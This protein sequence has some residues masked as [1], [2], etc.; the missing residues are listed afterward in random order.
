[1]NRNIILIAVAA[2]VLIILLISQIDFPQAAAA[3]PM[4]DQKQKLTLAIFGEEYYNIHTAT[5]THWLQSRVVGI[6][7]DNKLIGDPD[8][9]FEWIKGRKD[10]IDDYY[11]KY[12]LLVFRDIEQ[13]NQF[14]LTTH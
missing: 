8:V 11:P 1:M 4:P 10:N 14:L 12:V 6:K 5:N 13:R 2:V 7:Y 3:P 9:V